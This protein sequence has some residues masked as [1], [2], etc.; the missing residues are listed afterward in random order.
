MTLDI[1]DHFIATPMQDPEYMRAQL[2]YMP[3]DTRKRHDIMKIV[4]NDGWVY[5][6]IQKVMPGLKQAEILA[7][8]NLKKSLEPHGYAPIEG[9]V[10]MWK[11][12]KR[13]TKFC[14]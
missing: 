14:L 1:K 12:N 4:T 9:T 2:K 7:C 6:K 10:G 8:Q 13:P 3:E 5:I 11:Q